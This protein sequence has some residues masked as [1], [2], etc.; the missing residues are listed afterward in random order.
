MVKRTV[1]RGVD[2][3]WMDGPGRCLFRAKGGGVF[4]VVMGPATVTDGVGLR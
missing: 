2:E 4:L 1:I 3:G